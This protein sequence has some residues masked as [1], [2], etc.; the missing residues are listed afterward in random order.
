MLFR[1]LPRISRV[2]V[3]YYVEKSS[4]DIL[5][6]YS[7]IL[8]MRELTVLTIKLYLSSFRLFSLSYNSDKMGIF[9]SEEYIINYVYD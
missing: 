2:I 8:H 6:E 9:G 4:L 1:L 7:V 5:C 3:T